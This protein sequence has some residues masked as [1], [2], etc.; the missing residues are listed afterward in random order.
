M[1]LDI[2]CN[3]LKMEETDMSNLA[4]KLYFKALSAKTNALKLLKNEKGETNL[5]AIILILAVV[6]A[7]VVIFR[8]EIE[9]ILDQIWGSIGSDVSSALN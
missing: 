6:I 9:D 4:K 8:G 7:L 2:N 3:L 1:L 5:V